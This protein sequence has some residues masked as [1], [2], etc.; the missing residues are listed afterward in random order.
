MDSMSTG[1]AMALT[2]GA[3]SVIAIL[4]FIL[5][6]LAVGALARFL[7]PGPDPMSLPATAGFGIAGSLVGGIIGRLGAGALPGYVLSVGGAM[8]LIWFFTRRN[9]GASGAA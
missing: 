4:T 8:L 6:G 5:I 7:L 1:T 9:K 3:V 2:F